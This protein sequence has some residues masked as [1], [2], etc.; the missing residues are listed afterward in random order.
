MS[1]TRPDGGRIRALTPTEIEAYDVLPPDLA[2]RVRIVRVPVLAGPFTGMAL[3]RFVLLRID[4]APDGR[5]RLLAHEL[6]HVR[7]WAELGVV[8]FL[9]RYVTDFVRGLVATRDWNEA[10]RRI[11]A[12]VEARDLTRRWWERL[13]GTAGPR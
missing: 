10:Y 2:G 3:G 7:Q 6:I 13:T 1:S 12:E 4:V 8:G 11:G 5:S 9:V